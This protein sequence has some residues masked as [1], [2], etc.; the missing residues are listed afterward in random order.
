MRIDLLLSED[1]GVE[2]ALDEDFSVKI[3][4]DDL[5]CGEISVSLVNED[6][7]GDNFKGEYLREVFLDDT[8]VRGSFLVAVEDFNGLLS[9]VFDEDSLEGTRSFDSLDEAVLLS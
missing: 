8:R 6:L 1:T 4:L 2:V 9:T 3:S 7:A 5:S